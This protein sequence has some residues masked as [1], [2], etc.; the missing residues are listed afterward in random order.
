MLELKFCKN[1]E[2]VHFWGSGMGFIPIPRG[3]RGPILIHIRSKS[4]FANA[5]QISRDR[6]TE[7]TS[8][9]PIIHV[10]TRNERLKRRGFNGKIIV[11]SDS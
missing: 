9:E 8:T 7:R 10:Q 6:S 3:L 11:P 1:L 5:C 4:L 2:R